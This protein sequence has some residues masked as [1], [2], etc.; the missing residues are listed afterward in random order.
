[1]ASA[2][3]KLLNDLRE[4]RKIKKPVIKTKKE[5][6]FMGY[7]KKALAWIN[8]KVYKDNVDLRVLEETTGIFSNK[9]KEK[10]MKEKIFIGS[11]NVKM[12][13]D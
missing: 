3:D 5:R 1:M 2:L 9:K 12:N 7:N 6:N 10:V 11:D 4:E 13:I 8:K